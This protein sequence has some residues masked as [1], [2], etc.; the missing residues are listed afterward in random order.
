MKTGGGAQ[1]EASV[2]KA[3]AVQIE[4]GVCIPKTTEMLSGVV[5]PFVVPS[6]QGG[7]GIPE[8]TDKQEQTY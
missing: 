5:G 3:L 8:Q 7:R 6:S 2:V 4:P 1:G